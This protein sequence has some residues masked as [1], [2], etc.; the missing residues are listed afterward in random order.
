MRKITLLFIFIPCLVVLAAEENFHRTCLIDDFE[1]SLSGWKLSNGNSVSALQQKKAG[2]IITWSD[3]CRSGEKSLQAQIHPGDGWYEALLGISQHLP[4]WMQCKP[5]E[6]V[7]WL[8]GDGS[9]LSLRIGFRGWNKKLQLIDYLVTVSLHN[10]SWQ[11]VAIPFGRMQEAQPHEPFTLLALSD[12]VIRCDGAASPGQFWIDDLCVRNSGAEQNR[13]MTDLFQKEIAARSSVLNMPRIGS[14]NILKRDSAAMDRYRQTRMGFLSNGAAYPM[15]EYA[16]LQGMAT[17]FTPARLAVAPLLKSLHLSPEDIDQDLYGRNTVEKVADMYHSD[18]T[19]VFHPDFIKQFAEHVAAGVDFYSTKPWICSFMLPAPVSLYG[20]VHYTISKD[21]EFPAFS[22]P[23]RENFRA[24]LKGAYQN[25]LRLLEKA[26]GQPFS[27]W[28]D[29]LPPY[30]PMA[31]ETGI[32]RRKCWSDFM[33]WYNNWLEEISGQ[34]L[35]AARA[36]TGK[37][38]GLI[39]GGPKIGIAQG[40]CSGN[41]GALA[42]ILGKYG[43]A[44]LNDTD[45]Q[46]LFSVKYSRAAC[47]QYRV[48]LMAEYTGPPYLAPA[49][50][51]NTAI[52][53]LAGATDI[54]HF[55]PGQAMYDSS[56]WLFSLMPAV[57]DVI[58]NYRT[59]YRK[60][61]I[62][63]LHS[64]ITS[65]YR[66][67]R[68]NA[69]ALRIY[70]ATNMLWFPAK[71]YPSWGRALGCPDVID[72]VMLE[73]G[74]LAGRK[75]L[76]IPNSSVTLTTRNAVEGLKQWVTSGGVLVGFGKGCLSYTIENDRA[77]TPTPA[78]AGMI[79]VRELESNQ[80]GKVEKR[81][82]KGKVVLFQPPADPSQAFSHE[83]I[84]SLVKAAEAAGIKRMCRTDDRD[85]ANL[86]YCGKDAVSGKH[87]FVADFTRFVRYGMPG[88]IFWCDRTFDL[89]FDSSLRGEAELIT[90]SDS[91]DSCEGGVVEYNDQTYLLKVRFVLPGRLELKFGAGRH[92]FDYEKYKDKTEFPSYLP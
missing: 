54:S 55:A 31:D 62:A 85:D 26:W 63:I 44:F 56:H 15:Q 30:G 60:S 13:F 36:K 34:T 74:A 21:A 37:P 86:V 19:V 27:N 71:G 52:N 77:I 81:I 78:M 45:A 59:I 17:N 8:R 33:F 69:D 40:V 29:I 79:P 32:D 89:Y 80:Q 43:P 22:R 28:E 82:G 51:F 39:L 73:D 87:I 20:E 7:L 5:D 48:Q 10:N 61:E 11:Q 18:E 90:F 9:A 14:W 53:T 35:A 66:G 67:D 41:T 70:D 1:S 2:F 72:D 47:A 76:V 64:Y 49:L 88:V 4:E 23:A 12:V 16:F 42:K 68:S 65:W 83:V 25:D 3:V 46:T 50:Q 75:M 58:Q 84:P 91:Y 57:S 24:W 92:T 38:I 6:L